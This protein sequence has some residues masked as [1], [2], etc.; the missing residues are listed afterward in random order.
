MDTLPLIERLSLE[1]VSKEGYASLRCNWQSCPKAIVSPVVGHDDSVWEIKGLWAA[2]YSQFFPHE[3][4]PESVAGP[5]CAQF[6][7]SREAVRR[8]PIDKYEQVR[9]WIWTLDVMSADYKAGQVMEMM[10]HILFGKPAYYCPPAKECYCGTWGMC[11][12]ECEREGWCLGRMWRN[13]E[14]NKQVFGMA[15]P[16]PVS[17]NPV[18][19]ADSGGSC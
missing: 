12:L 15:K 16:I 5:C 1:H 10:W 11:D 14:K 17:F 3:P 9:Q 4:V 2:A 6:A 19:K 18:D 7:V 8:L 13:P